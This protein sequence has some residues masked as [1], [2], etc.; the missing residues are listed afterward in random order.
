MKVLV[1]GA[2]GASGRRIVQRALAAG[3][4]VTGFLRDPG[5]MAVEHPRLRTA[6]GDVTVASTVQSAIDG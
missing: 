4:E 1:L 3:H 5:A 6:A 2:S